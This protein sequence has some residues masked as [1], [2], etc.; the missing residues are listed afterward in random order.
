MAE[1]LGK[2]LTKLALLCYSSIDNMLQ[3]SVDNHSIRYPQLTLPL[4]FTGRTRFLDAAI[5]LES[6][7]GRKAQGYIGGN[8]RGLREFLGFISY[9]T[10]FQ[11]S[12]TRQWFLG[13]ND[14]PTLRVGAERI[15]D[16]LHL[17][18]SAG[19]GT[20]ILIGYQTSQG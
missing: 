20:K 1:T 7:T 11:A 8:A 6:G 14:V 17:Y 9:S 16:A 18:G 15:I 19:E 2:P 4:H 13:R 10:D 12:R 5:A 3:E